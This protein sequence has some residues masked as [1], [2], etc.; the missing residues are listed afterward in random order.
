MV[1][2]YSVIRSIQID[3]SRQKVTLEFVYPSEKPFQIVVAPLDN[4]SRKETYY[5]EKGSRSFTFYSD[6][7]VNKVC[8]LSIIVDG[9]VLESHKIKV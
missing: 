5:V 7:V 8:L 9:K 4:I 3:K 6:S 1:N 2:F